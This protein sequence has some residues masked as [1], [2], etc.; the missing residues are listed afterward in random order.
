MYSLIFILIKYR[1]A[2]AFR[3][4]PYDVARFK[5]TGNYFEMKSTKYIDPFNPDV[6][7][8]GFKCRKPGFVM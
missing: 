8:E 1:A 4:R 5:D 2:S 3:C 7:V 6:T